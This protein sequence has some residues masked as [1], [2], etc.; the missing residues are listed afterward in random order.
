MLLEKTRTHADTPIV[1]VYKFSLLVSSADGF[2][3]AD[4]GLA[5]QVDPYRQLS[6]RYK[7]YLRRKGTP[8]YYAP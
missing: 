3:I 6:D 4:F 5:E 7:E 1:K 8:G 2:K